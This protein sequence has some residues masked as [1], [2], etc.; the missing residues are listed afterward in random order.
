MKLL[1]NNTAIFKD[2]Q[3]VKDLTLDEENN[4]VKILNDALNFHESKDIEMVQKF[5]YHYENLCQFATINSGQWLKFSGTDKE[6]KCKCNT[7]STYVA[8][9]GKCAKCKKEL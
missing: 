7:G 6:K 3:K 9:N 2:R 8:K 4:V 5:I 1:F